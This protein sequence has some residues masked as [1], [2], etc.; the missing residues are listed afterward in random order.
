LKAMPLT[1]IK[2]ANSD[3]LSDETFAAM[4]ARNPEMVAVNVPDRGHVPFLDEPEAL[5]AIQA[6]LER[7]K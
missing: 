5:A 3:L 1:A 4:Q 6:F 2:G 7:V